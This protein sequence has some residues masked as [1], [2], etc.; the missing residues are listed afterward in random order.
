V[1][2]LLLS[3]AATGFARTCPCSRVIFTL[4]WGQVH[5][6][7][8]L[9]GIMM[10]DPRNIELVRQLYAAFVRKD[11]PSI[12]D[13]QAEDTQWSVAGSPEQIP[14]AAPR[15]GRA[16][17]AD[18]LKILSEWLIAEQFEIRDYLESGNKVVALGYQRGH[19][20]PSAR[21]YEFDFVHVWTLHEGKI[22]GFRVY[23]DTAY[24]AAALRGDPG[25]I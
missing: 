2:R 15:P 6:T 25:V 20:R 9:K 18:F 23:Y 10:N 8:V 7:L 1:H 16:G 21:P 17:V 3:G 4:G 12:L 22:T 13:L 11:L 24:V 14:W 19:V 5:I